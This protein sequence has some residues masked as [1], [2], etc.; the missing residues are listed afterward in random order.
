M[1]T[2]DSYSE[3]D[4]DNDDDRQHI[5]NFPVMKQ[6][7]AKQ[8]KQSAKKDKFLK[9]TI[10]RPFQYHNYPHGKL[11]DIIISGSKMKICSHWNIAFHESFSELN[12]ENDDN[13]HSNIPEQV[14]TV[15]NDNNNKSERTQTTFFLK[16]LNKML[17]K[18]P[19]RTQNRV[20]R[21]KISFLKFSN[22]NCN[23]SNRP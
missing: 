9:S 18:D 22:A 16:T 3:G 20:D 14:D 2:I 10:P 21:K 8:C 13:I 5:C 17:Q 4:N 11:L 1:V 12:D 7:G 6:E 19:N 23:S 15:P